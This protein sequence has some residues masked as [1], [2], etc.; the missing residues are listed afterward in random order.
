MESFTGSSLSE[1][2]IR[3]DNESKMLLPASDFRGQYL[4]F[5]TGKKAFCFL[6]F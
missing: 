3:F 6:I 5:M 4:M 1:Q 2:I